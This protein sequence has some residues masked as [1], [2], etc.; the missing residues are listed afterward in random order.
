METSHWWILELLQRWSARKT[1][2][3]TQEEVAAIRWNVPAYVRR[4]V[5]IPELD[6]FRITCPER[7]R[8]ARGDGRHS[9]RA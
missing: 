6:S 7:T 9:A 8:S 2:E 5:H 4:R 3:Q 1:H